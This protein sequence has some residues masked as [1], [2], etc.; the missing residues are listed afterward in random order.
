M[1]ATLH[2]VTA[3]AVSAL[4]S[5]TVVLGYFSFSRMWEYDL[6]IPG[7]GVTRIQWLS[8]Y[9]PPL[10]GTLGDSRVF[11]LDSGEPGATV[12][13]TA[14]IHPD[15]HATLAGIILVER[16]L[17]R[18]G[19]L[20]VVPQCNNSAYTHN[21]PLEAT[22]QF[23]HLRDAEGGLRAFRGGSRGANPIHSWPDPDVFVHAF[24]GQKFPGEAARDVNRVFP[25]R[26]DG[27]FTE[28]VAY[29]ITRMARAEQADLSIDLHE[30]RP[31]HPLIKAMDAHEKNE[32]LSDSP[33]SWLALL[34]TPNPAS[35]RLRGITDERLIIEGKDAFYVRAAQLGKTSVPFDERGWPLSLRVAR[36]LAGVRTLLAAYSAL[37]PDRAVSLANIPDYETLCATPVGALL[38]P[39]GRATGQKEYRERLA[40]E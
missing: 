10:Q 2:T 29:A 8:D 9:F 34:E 21:T 27:T 11:F 24:T 38:N 35:G 7:A 22:P 16:A 33:Q 20:I 14:G 37:N 19:R 32:S 23:F 17:P 5:L 18:T 13:V 4:V 39:A 31:E 28:Q 26:Q 3:L 30:A 12:T 25:G 6:I 36:H 15:E 1:N 40:F